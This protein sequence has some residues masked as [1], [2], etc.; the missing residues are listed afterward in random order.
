MQD[1]TKDLV[2]DLFARPAEPAAAPSVAAAPLVDALF[3]ASASTV[4]ST[5]SLRDN[6][7][8]ELTAPPQSRTAT[9]TPAA[10]AAGGE[11]GSIE[12]SPYSAAR[13]GIKATMALLRSNSDVERARISDMMSS[14]R[15][16][17]A[18]TSPR[19]S[20]ADVE[21]LRASRSAA[22]S[23]TPATAPALS[24]APPPPAAP[25]SPAVE[26]P[27]D[28]SGR[29]PPPISTP[30]PPAS[31]PAAPPPESSIPA[32]PEGSDG[33]TAEEAPQA[34]PQVR[35]PPRLALKTP[36]PPP[37]PPPASDGVMAFSLPGEG[38]GSV[39][40]EERGSKDSPDPAAQFSA[41]HIACSERGMSGSRGGASS[42]ESERLLSHGWRSASL[43]L[44]RVAARGERSERSR[45]TAPAEM[46]LAS[47]ASLSQSPLR[48]RSSV[49]VAEG[50][51]K[52]WRPSSKTASSTPTA[53][54]STRSS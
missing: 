44:G 36:P 8:G 25:C 42:A 3:G 13:E 18:P 19:P 39:E 17:I 22:E 52:G 40:R 29:P 16:A 31:S 5:H 50:P 28:A 46:P 38:G 10:A 30:P 27:L 4:V 45:S 12:L 14:S 34:A 54:T 2:D 49:A 7:F 1:S 11:A 33:A 43:A 23:R 53:H 51:R 9:A 6:V 37:P 15:R 41:S 47:H 26:I 21:L 24:P 35:I 48:I 32:A 20:R